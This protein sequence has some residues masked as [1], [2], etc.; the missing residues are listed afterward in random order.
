[1]MKHTDMKSHGSN[2]GP[3]TYLDKVLGRS[4]RYFSSSALPQM[5]RPY[6]DGRGHASSHSPTPTEPQTIPPKCLNKP[7]SEVGGS[8]HAVLDLVETNEGIY[9]F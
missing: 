4:S 8:I 7:G 6:T 5:P 2:G 3:A 1:M 9:M